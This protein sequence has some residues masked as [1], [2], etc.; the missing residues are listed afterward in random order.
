MTIARSTVCALLLL[1]AACKDAGVEQLATAKAKYA[2]LIDAGKTPQQP[3]FDE[4]MKELG[5]IPADSKASPEAVKLKTGIERARASRVAPPLAPA[6]PMVPAV[7]PSLEQQRTELI[8]ARE[9]CARLAASIGTSKGPQRKAKFE[10]LDACQRRVATM[11]EALD[12]AEP[13]AGTPHS[14]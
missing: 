2:A 3:E 11:D 9:E 5:A 10:L 6:N 13:D 1:T 8:A 14:P 12:H 7:D 4:L